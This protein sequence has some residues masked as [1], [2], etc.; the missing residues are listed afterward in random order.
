MQIVGLV[1][2]ILAILMQITDRIS[3][4]KMLIMAVA[5]ISLFYIGRLI[6]GYA[7]R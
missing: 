4:G 2:P 6:E 1:L 5:A 7:Q 3:V